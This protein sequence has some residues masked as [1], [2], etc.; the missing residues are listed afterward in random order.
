MPCHCWTVS[1]RIH[2]IA[3]ALSQVVPSSRRSRELSS[4]DECFTAPKAGPLA[5]VRK[6]LNVDE[7]SA[8]LNHGGSEGFNESKKSMLDA[9][10]SYKMSLNSPPDSSEDEQAGIPVP[11]RSSVSAACLSPSEDQ[12]PGSKRRLTMLRRRAT[13]PPSSRNSALAG[14]FLQPYKCPPPPPPAS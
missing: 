14:E 11:S 1:L 10:K 13:Q 5:A 9:A 4:Y 3:F 12:V 7:F 2:A 8:A 6:A